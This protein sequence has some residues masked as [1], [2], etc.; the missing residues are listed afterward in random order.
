[1]I[2]LLLEILKPPFR[3]ILPHENEHRQKSL[4]QRSQAFSLQKYR[5]ESAR[6]SKK[7][8][9]HRRLNFVRSRRDLA[10]RL[11]RIWVA[12]SP[13]SSH[14]PHLA[15]SQSFSDMPSTSLLDAAASLS[16]NS[17]TKSPSCQLSVSSPQR[18]ERRMRKGSWA[19]GASEEGKRVKGPE[20]GRDSAFFEES[21]GR[22]TVK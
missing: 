16:P 8:C 11:N 4:L 15:S 5:R 9:S 17:S 21:C 19:V 18:K 10:P 22:S 14:H 12:V 7:I 13:S 6:T 1:M 2:T 20:R 3:T